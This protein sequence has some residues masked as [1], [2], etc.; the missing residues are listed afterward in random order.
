MTEYNLDYQLLNGII[1]WCKEHGIDTASPLGHEV[2]VYWKDRI[3]KITVKETYGI[4]KKTV[5]TEDSS[6]ESIS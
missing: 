4:P 1:T 3:F 6:K 2:H 5:V